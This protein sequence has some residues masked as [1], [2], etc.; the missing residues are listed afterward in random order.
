MTQPIYCMENIQPSE[1]PRERLM[2]YGPKSLSNQELMAILFR[3][4]TKERSV[5]ELSNYFLNKFSQMQELEHVTLE[6]LMEIKGVGK[7][8]GIHL[9]ASIELGRRVLSRRTE[10]L[11]AVKSPSDA[12]AYL[13]T[14][15]SGLK[16]EHFKALY[17]NVKNEV[18][19]E[20][21]IFI[22][23][24]NSSIVHPRELFRE[25]VK[26]SAASVLV[27]HN[28]PSGNVEPSPEDIKVT[29]RLVEA[30]AIIGIDCVDHIIIANHRYIS[31]KEKG[32]M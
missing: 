14:E 15:M 1:R 3:T 8:K 25:A 11:Y 27:A 21:T 24:L 30:G 16:Q 7:V 20:Q 17:L 19:H 13:M 5:L 28:H 29:K 2:K 4:G 9:L 23:G 32:Y 18:I 12:A 10:D 26:R 22:G 6:E 31:L